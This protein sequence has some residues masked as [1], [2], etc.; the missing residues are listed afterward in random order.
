MVSIAKCLQ[1]C[2]FPVAN[3]SNIVMTRP[4]LQVAYLAKLAVD[5][6]I[7]EGRPTSVM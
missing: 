7:L 1:G 5:S 4:S 6:L 2:R 3:N